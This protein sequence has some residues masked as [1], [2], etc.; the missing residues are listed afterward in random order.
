MGVV[1]GFLSMLGS[2][3]EH[4]GVKRML[5]I[6]TEFERIAKVVVDKAEKDTTTRKKRKPA[7][8]KT[9]KTNTA[10]PRGAEMSN[11]NRQPSVMGPNL[12]PQPHLA[13]QH[14][15]MPMPDHMSPVQNGGMHSSVSPQA[16]SNQYYG[17]EPQQQPPHLDYNHPDY[18]SPTGMT[19][20]ADIQAYSQAN[21]SNAYSNSS[22]LMNMNAFARPF[23]PQDLWQMPMALEWDWAEMTAG[24]Y[25][26]GAYG[27]GGDGM[28]GG[29]FMPGN[30]MLGQSGVLPL[31]GMGN[32]N[33]ERR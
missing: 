15:P 6:C 22:P 8:D 5:G 23:V 29:E 10:A 16:M 7:E 13:P 14:G 9:T 20:Y 25:D 21:A 17:N 33:D 3:E 4:G 12:Y 26:G 24:A 1:V 18:R 11:M 32:G 27:V 19:P 2:D 31:N 28:M 30:G